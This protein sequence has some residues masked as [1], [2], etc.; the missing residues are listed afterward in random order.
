MATDTCILYSFVSQS[1]IHH[2]ES[3]VSPRRA[4]RGRQHKE[5]TPHHS[6][7]SQDEF[8]HFEARLAQADWDGR[9]ADGA[10]EA[11]GWDMGGYHT[12]WHL[13]FRHDGVVRTGSD[14][15]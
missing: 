14:G 4:T 5:S 7:H 15:E 1:P 12:V 2:V 8:G 6:H 11:M 9:S 13:G 10:D 3:T